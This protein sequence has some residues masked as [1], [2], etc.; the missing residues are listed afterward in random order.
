VFELRNYPQYR[1]LI[2]RLCDQAEDT[3][4]AKSD[5]QYHFGKLMDEFR[6]TAENMKNSK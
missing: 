2:L 1:E 3:F 6:L 4:S 5:M